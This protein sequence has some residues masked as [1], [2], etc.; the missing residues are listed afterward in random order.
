[1]IL[2]FG[3]AGLAMAVV[4][5]SGVLGCVR[6]KET[7]SIAKDGRVAIEVQHEGST[8]EIKRTEMD[9]WRSSGW[10]VEFD[11]TVK[12]DAE[13]GEDKVE[14]HKLT[15]AMSF[16]PGAELPDHWPTEDDAD[17]DLQLHFPTTVTV[18]QRGGDTYYRFHRFYSPRR[19]AYIEYWKHRLLENDEAKQVREKPFEELT[20]E[21]KLQ[22]ARAFLMVEGHKQAELV[23]AA[24]DE[25]EP[26]MAVED[27]TLVQQSLL[28]VYRK[29]AEHFAD[30]MKQCIDLEEEQ[31]NDCFEQH[32]QRLLSEGGDAVGSVL[33]KALG[34]SPAQLLA[35]EQSQRRASDYYRISNTIGGHRFD[36]EVKLPGTVVAHNAD[37]I[38][39]QADGTTVARWDFDG[40][41]F[42]DR[43]HELI[44]VSR[45]GAGD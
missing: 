7:I 14:E 8:Q 35:Y 16:E 38:E 6:R 3:F 15:A 17:T 20:D 33:R 40:T 30:P 1:M 21:E 43:T 10:K 34:L 32:V 37:K 24:L 18:E 13:T 9:V 27:R 12:R 25:C 44:V 42:R 28:D 2:R 19:W 11:E 4:L 26:E 31:R 39:T 29:A 36:I 45:L 5:V 22:L 41:A 23:T